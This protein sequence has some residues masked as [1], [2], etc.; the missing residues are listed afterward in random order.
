ME[1]EILSN[2]GIVAEVPKDMVEISQDTVSFSPF[3]G[4]DGREGSQKSHVLG[5]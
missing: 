3:R 2:P 4:W 5:S 1:G